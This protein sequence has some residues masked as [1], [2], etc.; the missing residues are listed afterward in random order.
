M[1]I[2]INWKAGILLPFLQLY[3]AL[4][5]SKRNTQKSLKED[6]LLLQFEAVSVQV[7]SGL[8][9]QGSQLGG[10]SVNDGGFNLSFFL[11]VWCS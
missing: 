9:G 6:I 8:G 10:R 11:S 7:L 4:F 1:K 3:I 5:K 2:N